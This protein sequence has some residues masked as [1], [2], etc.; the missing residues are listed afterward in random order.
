[1]DT[2]IILLI[3]ICISIMLSVSIGGIVYLSQPNTDSN[4]EAAKAVSAAATEA[5]AKAASA[6]TASTAKAAS[7]ATASA[8]TA[9]AATASAA[10]ASAATAAATPLTDQQ[11]CDS[12]KAAYAKNKPWLTIDAWDQYVKYGQFATPTKEIWKG[13]GCPAIYPDA[14]NAEIKQRCDAETAAYVK[15]GHLGSDWDHYIKYGI[16][17][18]QT[19]SG[20]GCPALYPGQEQTAQ[21]LAKKEAVDKKTLDIQ[22]KCIA[23]QAKYGSKHNGAGWTEYIKWG[24]KEGQIWDGTGCP[25]IYPGDEQ[26]QRLKIEKKAS[27][28]EQAK[29]DTAIADTNDKLL[30]LKNKLQLIADSKVLLSTVTI[31]GS[32]QCAVDPKGGPNLPGAT[33]RL[34]SKNTLRWYPD[35][36]IAKSWNLNWDKNVTVLS[37]CSD[38]TAGPKMELKPPITWSSYNGF[39]AIQA[40]DP[41]DK[42]ARDCSNGGG[43]YTG[44]A[45][46]N[47]PGCNSWCCQPSSQE[48]FNTRISPA[49]VAVA[50]T[51][52]YDKQARDCSNSGGVYTG[53][54]N[55]KFLGC[56]GYCCK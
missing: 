38:F 16:S 36:N 25:D 2:I 32:V 7:A 52:P 6:A 24:I 27:D 54:N 31:G 3:V 41:Y 21:D 46:G 30:T 28:A 42:Q 15:N 53:G 47:F 55:Q 29:I 48:W 8:A 26:A 17:D 49:F 22:N 12:E 33:Y 9:S 5:A 4:D 35:E 44:G 19:W 43:V 37:N 34:D 51:D 11:K 23:E 56:T 20:P 40:S 1:M 18:G 13:P 14:T 50:P 39:I 10:T 45:N